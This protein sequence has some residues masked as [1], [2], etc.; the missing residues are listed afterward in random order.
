MT[1]DS[2]PT[3]P[4]PP[5]VVPRWEWR[6]FGDFD[7]ASIP[8]VLSGADASASDETY[9]LS[10]SRDASVKVRGGLLD[11]KVL[12][13]VDGAGLQLWIPTLKA[14]FPLDELAAT[15]AFDALGLPRPRGP[16]YSLE[17][18]VREM[19][20]YPDDVRVV[21]VRKVRHRSVLDGC[22]VEY[23]ELTADGLSTR[24]VAVE[25][26]DTAL[27]SETVGRLGLDGRPNTCIAKG[28]RALLG[29]EP[30]RFGVL[31]VG[32]NSVKL[33]VCLRQGDGLAAHRTRHSSRHPAW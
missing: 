3:S 32:T 1:T 4:I 8:A 7:G 17:E 15:A 10:R 26:P 19:V 2:L 20:S 23:T 13:H 24:T 31:D 29:W 18:L 12:Q 5:A 14:A 21:A 25:S 28:I 22:M 9:F 11:I 27:V 33:N 30:S 6:S 16:R